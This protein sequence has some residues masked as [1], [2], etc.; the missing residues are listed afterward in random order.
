MR[1]FEEGYV[2][3]KNDTSFNA[4]INKILPVSKYSFWKINSFVPCCFLFLLIYCQHLWRSLI[5]FIQYKW[6]RKESRDIYWLHT[7]L[8]KIGGRRMPEW[9]IP[10]LSLKLFELFD[11]WL[12]LMVYTTFSHVFS[13][14]NQI[15][16]CFS[17]LNYS[18]FLNSWKKDRCTIKKI[19]QNS[20]GK[21]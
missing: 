20:T 3:L 17:P 5:Y 7:F 19:N 14:S 21:F 8:Q 6:R 2:S 9:V 11:L 4:T 18:I 12:H 15:N 16:K 13:L 1:T 10:I